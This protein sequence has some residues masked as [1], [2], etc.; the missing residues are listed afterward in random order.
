[1]DYPGKRLR[2]LR[3]AR[4]LTQPQVAEVTGVPQS[5]LSELERGESQFPSSPVL[6]K[7]AAFY[8][9]EPD[10]IVTGKGPKHMVASRG[11]KETELL[12]YYRSL[13]PEGQR[14]ILARARDLH[15]DE[16]QPKTGT[17]RPKPDSS[18]Q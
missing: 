13:S 6:S 1:M 4:K 18:L 16:H 17:P 10:W 14:Y 3:K 5:T 7:L 15:A 8:E 9:V 2:E 12:L 11:E